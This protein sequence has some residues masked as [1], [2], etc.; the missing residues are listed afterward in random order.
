VRGQTKTRVT[1][2]RKNQKTQRAPQQVQKTD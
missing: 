1:S 2:V